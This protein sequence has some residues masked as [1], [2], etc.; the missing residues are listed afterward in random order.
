MSDTSQHRSWLFRAILTITLIG[1]MP[2]SAT[3]ASPPAVAPSSHP[4]QAEQPTVGSLPLPVQYAFSSDLGRDDESYHLK[5]TASGAYAATNSGIGLSATFSLYGMEIRAGAETWSLGLDGWGR[6]GALGDVPAARDSVVNANRL[7]VERGP[8]TEWYANGPLGLQQGWILARAPAGDRDGPLTLGLTQ[9]GSL[10]GRVDGEGATGMALVDTGGVARLRYGGLLAHDAAGQALP[11]WFE[12]CGERLLVRVDDAGASYPVM[13]DPWVQATKLTTSHGADGDRMGWAVAVSEDGGT[14]VVGVPYHHAGGGSDRGAVF[15]YTRPGE[16]VTTPLYTA[17]LTAADSAD[18]D[19]LGWAVA[20]SGDGGTVVAGAPAHD[21][22]GTACVFVRPPGGWVDATQTAELTAEDGVDSDGLGGSVA[23]SEDGHT[24][25]AGAPGADVV[26]GGSDR[27]AVYV[28]TRPAGGWADATDTA[29]L[30]ASDGEDGDSLGN[31][32][33]NSVAVSAD[34][35]T[36]IAGSPFNDVEPT[37][38]ARGAVYVYGRTAA[39]WADATETAK[40][41]AGNGEDGDML[42]W[43]VAVSGD[44]RSV[45]AGA[46]GRDAGGSDRGSAYVYTL[47]PGGWPATGEFGTRLIAGDGENGDNLGLSLGVSSDGRTVIAGAYLNDASGSNRGAAYVYLRPVTGWPAGALTQD[48]KLTSGDGADGDFLGQSVAMSGDGETVTAGAPYNAGG[49]NMRGAAYVYAKPGGW[50]TTT[51]TA[52]LTA[53]DGADRDH[54]G[55]SVALSGD[56][57]TVVAGAHEDDGRRGAA[58]VYTRPA[59]GWAATAAF[60][61]KLTAAD[62]L[63]GDELGFSVAVS[64]DGGT[65]IAG[66]HGSPGGNEWGAAYVFVRPPTGWATS[67][68]TAK[69]TAADGW[70]YD[71]L[72]LS[73]AVDADGETVIGG[74]PGQGGLP[75]AA[76]VF[77]RPATGWAD[78]THTAKLASDD[79]NTIRLGTSVAVSADGSVVAAGAPFT[80]VQTPADER[81][82]AFVF[83]RPL[84]GW[85]VGP[86]VTE[87]AKLI[88]YNGEFEELLGASVALS[89]NGWTVVAGAPFR[90]AGGA[91]FVFV[92][93]PSG[94]ANAT[95]TARLQASDGAADDRLGASVAVSEDG[96]TVVAGAPNNAAGGTERG[97]AYLYRRPESGWATT[98]AFDA[99]LAASDGMDYDYLARSVALSGNGAIAVAGVPYHDILAVNDNRGAAYA[100]RLLLPSTVYLPIVLR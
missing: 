79:S 61:A 93:P 51:E 33:G 17:K 97:A 92:R 5:A 68:E 10:R 45:I 73:V 64:G 41:T 90:S 46:P 24:V 55:R 50:A 94:W 96:R 28:F 6:E 30:T 100:F 38:A 34:G 88:A 20:V 83:V 8:I 19:K 21:G 58:Y 35:S 44:G 86:E 31:G 99:K 70:D 49:G 37:G 29:K 11:A 69:L 56:G 14:V 15:V 25:V 63:S 52:K 18:D 82:A 48:A 78:A 7:E 22:R 76:Y 87:T 95:H 84:D 23:V 98:S 77:E 67:T 80:G 59:G 12:A 36:V 91:A 74:A 16:W 85:P 9:G 4:S 62:R 65:V 13:I 72:G 1:L 2:L 47:P 89:G 3:P 81:G 39:D 40:L 71:Q 60:S 54:L 75:G 42:G 43:S 26:V 66:A 27:G 57:T 53:G 32:L